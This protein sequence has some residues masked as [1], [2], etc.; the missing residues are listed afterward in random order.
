MQ[1]QRELNLR[2]YLKRLTRRNF[3]FSKSGAMPDKINC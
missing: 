2:T 3:C 1:V